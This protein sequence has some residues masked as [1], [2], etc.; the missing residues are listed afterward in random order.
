MESKK[1]KRLLTIKQAAELI[2]GL[3]VYRVRQMC[4]M[5]QLAYFKAGNRILISEENL[6]KA[7]FGEEEK[8]E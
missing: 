1:K 6:F 4:H 3:S 2:D 7:V 8:D 5:N